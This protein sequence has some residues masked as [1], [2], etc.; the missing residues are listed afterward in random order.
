MKSIERTRKEIARFYTCCG[1]GYCELQHLLRYQSRDYYTTG[2][3]GWNMDVYTFGDYAIT[4]GYRSTIDHVKVNSDLVKYYDKK[5]QDIQNSKLSYEEKETE[6]K[7]L[8]REFIEKVF[9][10]SI[11]M[12]QL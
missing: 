7:L 2:V 6:T 5:A 12:E 3:Y 11:P 4:T 8:L 1:V 10:Y 9:G